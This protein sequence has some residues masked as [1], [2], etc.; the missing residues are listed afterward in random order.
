MT[1]EQRIVDYMKTNGS[2]S[3]LE[4]AI[5]IGTM[6]LRKRISDLRKS[7]LSIRSEWEES[8]N[9]YGDTVRYKRYYLEN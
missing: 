6:D 7:G 9:R 5:N 1:I 2:I 4:A 3:V 8:K